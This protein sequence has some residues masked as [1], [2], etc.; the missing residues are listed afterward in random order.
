MVVSRHNMKRHSK[1]A[2]SP[3]NDGGE[4][5]LMRL[6]GGVSANPLTVEVLKHF[7]AQWEWRDG[8]QKYSHWL[9]KERHELQRYCHCTSW[10]EL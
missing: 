3:G 9:W 10:V 6:V 1:E 7:L 8:K 4:F 5:K 2:F